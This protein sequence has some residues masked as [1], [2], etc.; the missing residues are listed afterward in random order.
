MLEKYQKRLTKIIFALLFL[1]PVVIVL[2]IGI[3]VRYI[4]PQTLFYDRDTV[5][6]KLFEYGVYILTALMFCCGLFFKKLRFATTGHPRLKRVVDFSSCVEDGLLAME[7]QEEK[8]K[9]FFSYFEKDRRSV[10]INGGTFLVFERATSS[11]VFA[12][13]LLG[14]LFIASA[15]LIF[16]GMIVNSA[17]GV[18]DALALVCAV[19][20]G[21]YFWLSGLKELYPH[22]K[23]FGFLSM[24]PV[25]WCVLRIISDFLDLSQNSNEY[26]HIMQIACLVF[27]TLFFYN[28]GKFTLTQTSRHSMWM[29]LGSGFASLI[30]ISAVSVPNLLL[31]SFW[32]VDFNTGVFNSMV[33]LAIG[34]YIVA[35]LVAISSKMERLD[36][37]SLSIK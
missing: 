22:A 8:R 7:G 31:A 10:P 36:P 33:E 28:E 1:I 18:I 30:L 24:A 27:L 37:K 19:L 16:A 23:A 14:F 11:G 13:T 21:F 25:I 35:K 17:L 4:D 32:M 20:S 15:V 29:Y 5:I 12:A 3:V 2:R 26:S 34:V 9:D 6:P